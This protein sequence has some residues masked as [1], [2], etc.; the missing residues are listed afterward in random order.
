MAQQYS[1]VLEFETEVE[2]VRMNGVDMITF[3]DDGR[4]T[5]FKVM[6]R[7][8]KAINLVH[9]LMGEQLAAAMSNRKPLKGKQRYAELPCPGRGREISAQRRVS[10][11]SLQ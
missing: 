8:L 9:R 7:P 2:G 6:I 3:A 11:R 1:A 10:F 4:I 5:H